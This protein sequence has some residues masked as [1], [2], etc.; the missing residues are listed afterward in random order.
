MIE[1]KFVDQIEERLGYRPIFHDDYI[2]KI[3]LDSSNIILEF[4]FLKHN[5]KFFKEHE[6]KEDFGLCVQFNNVSDVIFEESGFC[7]GVATLIFQFNLEIINDVIE[8]EVDPSCGY[9]FRFHAQSYL[10]L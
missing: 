1:P 3:T 10:I 8:I 6:M 5:A 4:K 9:Y 7:N 2:S